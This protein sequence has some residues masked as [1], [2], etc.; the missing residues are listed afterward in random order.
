MPENN[1]SLRILFLS[2]EADPFIKVGGLG[3]VAGSLPPAL[4]AIP[5]PFSINEVPETPWID[6][7]LVIPFHGAIRMPA[8]RLQHMAM[9]KVLH[10]NGAII[11]DVYLTRVNQMPV[12]MIAGEPIHPQAPVYSSDLG[13]DAHKYIFFSLAALEAARKIGFQPHI[14]HANDWHT[15]AAMYWLS[16]H[17]KKDTFY[18]KTSSLLTIHNLPFLG[19]GA[20]FPL[21]SFFLPPS[22]DKRLPDWAQQLPLPLGIL[23]A[24]QVTTVSPTYA[25]E[26]MTPEFGSGLDAFLRTQKQKI[27]GILN[28]IDQVRWNPASDS[29]LSV[30]YSKESLNLRQANKIALLNELGF[31]LRPHEV[32]EDI[33][34]IALV[35]RMDYQK[36]LD[37][38]VEALYQA[39]Y[40]ERKPQPKWRAVLLGTGLPELEESAIRLERRFPD[41]VR[42]VTRFDSPLSHRIY[43]GADMLLMPSRY[44][45]CGLSQLIAMRYGCVP[46]ARA[47][48]GLVDTIIDY[49][50]SPESTGFLFDTS[51]PDALSLAMQKAIDIY[52]DHSQWKALQLRGMEQDFSWNQSAQAYAKLYQQMMDEGKNS[53]NKKRTRGAV[54]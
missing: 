51:T 8:E 40:H 47:T 1:Q 13:Y 34:L 45:P 35:S 48:G 52:A 7:R 36:G 53:E 17:G 18:K 19:V 43:A 32:S 28:G 16:L 29:H 20:S 3:D 6:V 27:S 50:S 49:D 23:S 39:A 11:A 41:Y 12:Y 2:A 38:A 25:R 22:T 30:I 5:H 33:P 21:T 10:T 26:I 14:V 42:V 44:E 31:L 37:L 24:D 15:A 54:Q 4:R 46:I 9:I